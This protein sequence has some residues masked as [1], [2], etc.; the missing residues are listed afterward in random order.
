MP[1]RSSCIHQNKCPVQDDKYNY[2]E[3]LQAHLIE[4]YPNE[5]CCR[6]N[7]C[8]HFPYHQ[9]KLLKALQEVDL[10]LLLLLRESNLRPGESGQGN[11]TF[12]I[13]IN[14]YLTQRKMCISIKKCQDIV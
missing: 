5:H 2:H 14:S 4:E 6:G 9:S 1:V 8:L 10:Y 11:D 13:L 7:F 12:G 3:F